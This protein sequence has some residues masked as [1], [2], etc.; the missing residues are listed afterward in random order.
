[1]SA[2]IRRRILAWLVVRSRS[3]DSKIGATAWVT[4]RADGLKDDA[5]FGS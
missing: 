1:M 4:S 3:V 5:K 2:H